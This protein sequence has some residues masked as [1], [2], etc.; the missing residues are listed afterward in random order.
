M[1]NLT[2]NLE[3][4]SAVTTGQAKKSY[5]APQVTPYGNLVELVQLNPGTGPDGNPASDDTRS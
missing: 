3:N 1:N 4:N 2:N 5:H